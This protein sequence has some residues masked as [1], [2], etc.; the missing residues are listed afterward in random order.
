MEKNALDFIEV[1]SPSVKARYTAGKRGSF[2][3]FVE[4]YISGKVDV[5]GD[6]EE[7]MNLRS[8]YFD[9]KLT[10]HHVKFFFSRMIPEVVSHSKKQDERIVREHYDRGNDFFSYFLGPRMVYTGGFYIDRANETL[11]QA[12]DRKMTMVCEKL[13]MK[14]GD[15]HLDIGCGWGTLVAYAAKFYGT[16][17]TGITLAQDGTD[18]GNKQLAAHGLQDRARILRMDYRDMLYNP[19]NTQ[20]FD[21]ITCLE[22]GEHVGIRKF[23][24]FINKIYDKLNDDGMFYIQQAGL[25]ANPGIMKKGRHW[26]DLAWGLFMNEYIFSG[27]DASTPLGFLV[28]TLQDANFEV[29]TVENI[30]IHYSHTLHEWYK[31]WEKNKEAVLSTYGEWWYRLWRLFL[32]WSTVIVA[33][34]SSTCWSIAAYKN[35]NIDKVNRNRYI[36]RENLGERM[37][38]KNVRTFSVDTPASVFEKPVLS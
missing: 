27:A 29:Q 32:Y 7:F 11:E 23:Q 17:G 22:M 34:G 12:Q 28:K 33:N 1:K 2:G 37:M 21:K 10:G 4:D 16:D 14:P 35:L 9:F 31:N 25:R 20:K 5:K 30:G 24:G 3:H 6:F 13:M 36:G 18:H 26:E 8:T 38:L 19:S 15:K